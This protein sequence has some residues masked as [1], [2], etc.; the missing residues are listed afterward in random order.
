MQGR[1]LTNGADGSTTGKA[2]RAAHRHDADPFAALN[3]IERLEVG[4]VRIECKRI[5]TPYKV[6]VDGKED[7]TELAYRYEEDVFDPQDPLSCNLAA[8]ITAQVALNYGLFCNEIVFHG[9]FDGA[10]RRLLNEMAKN[11]AREILVKKFLEPNP[12]LVGAVT[13]LPAV[14]QA[15]Y[16]R[17]KLVFRDDARGPG[18]PA[19]AKSPAPLPAIDRAKH[20]VL[21]S[22]GKD[23]LLSYAL[24]REAGVE[25]H[26]VFVNESGK[27]WFTAL[28]AY[29]HFSERVPNTARVWTNADRVF[30]WMLRRLPF[31]RPDF[32]D[33]RSDEYPIRL[34]TV[35]VFLFG[36]L[37]VARRRGIGRIMIGD[38]F[39]TTDRCFHKDIPHYNGLFD[40]SR[41]FD[42]TLTRYYTQ[43]GWHIS[44]FSLLRSMSELLIQKTLAERY[45]DLLGLQ[46]SCHATHKEN[47]HVRPCGR[48]EKCRR[49]VGMLKA[50][51]ADPGACG[52]S[53]KQIDNCLAMLPEKRVHQES[54]GV[55]HLAYLLHEKGLLDRPVIGSRRA[56]KRSHILKMRF[57]PRRSPVETIPSDL[58]RAVHTVVLE[59]AN[60]AVRRN[61][62]LWIEYDPVDDAEL[63]KPYPF[64]ASQAAAGASPDSEDDSQNDSRFILGELTW[65]EAQARF[66]TVDVALLPVGSIEQHGPHL[67]LDTDAFDAQHLAREVA[68]GCTDP[69]PF[70]LPLIPYGVSYHHADF[71]GT[72][73]ISN[74]TLAKLV[75]EVGMSAA[76]NGITKLVIVN[77]HGGN[78]PALHFAAQLINRDAH[79]FTCVDSGE[80]S[81]T[82]INAMAETPSDI[83]AGEI[84][85]ST[86]MA[87]RP[88]LVRMEKA[89]KY[90]PRFSSKYLDFSSKRSVDWYARTAKLSNSGVMG[91]PT[92][93]SREKG[94]KMWAVMIKNLVELVEHLKGM[95][96][97]EIYQRNR[98]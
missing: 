12:F 42:N 84:E 68:Q 23:S 18:V 22:G 9:P 93:A 15:T 94:E 96:L 41:Y 51:G 2:D 8:M 73:S 3:V 79:I 49:I 1:R 61:G 65:P 20:M 21:S 29:R 44:Q 66:K 71:S 52:Y 77:G 83:H 54:D 82:D 30:S 35:A 27:H 81:D 5:V 28:N 43:K 78:A 60:G 86:A 38:E 53:P 74:E 58:R 64:E 7:A 80:T 95:S 45:P 13:E 48:C 34:W 90:V 37:A 72:I 47:D 36:A 24:L 69:R 62:R 67:P 85:T 98:Y 76:R 70:V 14:K 16:L 97:D 59:H 39:D 55:E 75:C 17:S 4:P 50:I 25:I 32:L 11:T 19:P 87:V 56:K 40:Q 10:D 46:M 33:V 91:D 26:P 88:A 6:S 89:R 57:D 31:I 63:A 92:K